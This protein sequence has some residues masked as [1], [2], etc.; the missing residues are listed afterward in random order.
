MERYNK[1]NAFLKEKFGERV[2]KICVDG[3]FTCPNRDGTKGTGGCA[4]CTGRGSGDHLKRLP[5]Q[6]QIKN[7]INSYRGDRANKYIVYFQSFSGTYAPLQML[8]A[9]YDEALSANKNIVGLFV[10]TRPDLINDDVCKLLAAYSS[11]HYVS[12]ELGLQ[13]ANDKTAKSLNMM[14]DS[15]DF[16][17]AVQTLN[18]YNIDVVAHVMVGLPDETHDDII[19][20]ISFINSLNIKGIKIHSTYVAKGTKLEEKFLSGSY[21]P[22][23]LDEYL[24]E[25][26]FII[27]HLRKDIVIHRI[28][29]DAPKELLVAPEWNKNKKLILNGLTKR[30]NEKNLY[31]GMF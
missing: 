28:S 18:K 25:L 27:T 26:E 30:L 4:F 8:R 23:S 6:E 1:L 12:V 11:S 10:A 9:K 17:K 24:N 14:Y 19:K 21:H 29:G 2:L 5:I 15:G 31:Q 22:L 7:H 16:K 3:G 13:S 20:T